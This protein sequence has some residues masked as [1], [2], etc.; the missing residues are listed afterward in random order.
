MMKRILILLILTAMIA[1]PL[2]AADC[3][4]Q[5]GQTA[6]SF[7]GRIVD[8]TGG[9][10]PKAS[11]TMQ[12]GSVTHSATA[13]DLGSF[14]IEVAP[15]RYEILVDAAG[16][17]PFAQHVNVLADGS[18]KMTVPMRI[19]QLG[20]IVT[21][22][23]LTDAPAIR[24]SAGTKTD[25]PLVETP[26]AVTVV[27][28]SRIEA[29]GAQGVQEA[30][31]YA[32]G[33][34]SD[35]FGL[36]SRTDS[37][38]VRG[39]YPDE[40]LDGM[41]QL[42]NYY[43]STT[44]TDPYLLER[45]EVLRGPS[46]MLYGQGTTAGIVNL[47][48][49]LPLAEE[50]REI[51]VQVGSYGRM[52]LQ[53]DLTGPLDEEGTWLY[54]LVA[55]GRQADTQVEHVGDDRRLIAPSLTWRPSSDTSLT[56]QFRWQ[57]DRSA[58]TLQFLP[59]SGNVTPNPNGQI[60]TSTFV[61]E[62]DFD[63]YDSDR[64][65]GGWLFQHRWNDRWTVRQ[66]FRIAK[67]KVDYR[68]L[69]PDSYSLP[70]T[71][72]LDPEERMLNR[73]AWASANDTRIITADQSVAGNVST[74]A[75]EHDLLFG[76][77]YV[78]FNESSKSMFD[79]PQSFGGGVAPIDAY[80]PV[81]QGY[82]GLPLSPDPDTN[83]NQVGFYVQDQMKFG[84]HWNVIAGLRH[85]RT[86]SGVE[87]SADSRSNATTARLGVL[88]KSTNGWSPYASYSE[89]FTPIAGLDF[90]NE[91]FDPMRG[92]QLEAGVKWQ[93]DG[94]AFAF[95][96]AVFDLRETNRLISDPENPLNQ[97]QAGETKTTGV[98][99]E[100]VG[101]I[102]NA[103]DLSA[104]YT[105]LDN[106]AQLDGVPA[107]QTALWVNRELPLISGLSGGFGVRYFS[108]FV[109]T[110]APETPSVLLTDAM[111]AWER[112]AWKYAL[113]V[114]NLEDK[115]YVSTCLGRGDCFYGARRNVLLT[116]TWRY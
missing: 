21:V 59:W 76:A 20:A 32:A 65:T 64:I 50:H 24:S 69:Y 109:D 5:A 85:D 57:Q 36:D 112:D 1:V 103:L 86:R 47:V 95:T 100:Y 54:R 56:M 101:R 25:T 8:P 72:Y 111:L 82:D 61:G 10:I 90:Y 81:Y 78:R 30:L 18:S 71:S 107:H 55:L 23:A 33:V 9:G 79:F 12:C 39:G 70:G 114:T 113:N 96:A 16:F 97:I 80:N 13:D 41:R 7:S 52:Q 42:F 102:A 51:G 38:L 26:Q 104:H 11:I 91:R 77:D 74:G 67:N 68:G 106:D 35:A 34:R 110:T 87:G 48:S 22:D 115:T 88:Y 58:S 15:G 45:I 93:P 62:P 92:K 89:S 49:K 105:Y 4:V 63:R 60:P 2:V 43:T 53:A 75:V 14:S 98:E 73:Y 84:P 40:Y 31:N 3:S 28:R 37:V 116:A 83:Q 94:K 27:T 66:N 17:D 6:V 29:T 99:L 46:S 19:S 108:A 44:R